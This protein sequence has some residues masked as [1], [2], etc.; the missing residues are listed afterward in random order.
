ML[1]IA[2]EL[3]FVEIIQ[4]RVEVSDKDAVLEVLAQF[5]TCELR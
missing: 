3:V 1:I 2:F 5:F 4:V